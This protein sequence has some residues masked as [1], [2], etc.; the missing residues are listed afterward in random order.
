MK[1]GGIKREKK[2]KNKLERGKKIDE[3]KKG[4]EMSPSNI[5]FTQTNKGLMLQV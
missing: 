4:R 2:K 5:K 1:R 3:K